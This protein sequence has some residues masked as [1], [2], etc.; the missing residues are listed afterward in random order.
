[1]E[2]EGI[3]CSVTSIPG[4]APSSFSALTVIHFFFVPACQFQNIKTTLIDVGVR[5]S[6]H[7][8]PMSPVTIQN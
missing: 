5:L 6:L 2:Q 8:G 3:V 1:M 4:A 7:P